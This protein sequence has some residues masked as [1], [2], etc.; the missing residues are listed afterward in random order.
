MPSIPASSIARCPGS[1]PTPNLPYYEFLAYGPNQAP[2]VG[3]DAVT[4]YPDQDPAG[5]ATFAPPDYVAGLHALVGIL[6]ALRAPR[7]NRRGHELDVS[8]FETTVS[9][10]GP[11]LI[12]HD[13][14]G[15]VL[16]RDGNRVPWA[17]PQGCY[18]C[19]GE[20]RFVAISV[21]E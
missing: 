20:D 21:R 19:A 6:S 10:L 11:H 2:L 5:I 1:A 7:R 17:A 18:P 15:A 12:D 13:R 3:L 4:G 16:A 14:S 8:Q 9:L